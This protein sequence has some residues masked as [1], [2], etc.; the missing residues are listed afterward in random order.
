MAL[1]SP[2]GQAR[3]P[4]RFATRLPASTLAGLR[5]MDEGGEY[6]ELTIELAATLA[7]TRTPVT[8]A[9]QRELR[10]TAKSNGHADPASRSAGGCARRG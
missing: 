2:A 9:E 1:R 4:D 8:P 3:L 10:R 6:G 7:R 5:A